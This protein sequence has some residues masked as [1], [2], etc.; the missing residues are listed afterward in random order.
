VRVIVKMGFEV[1]SG[2]I[3][4]MEIYSI[5]G[6]NLD[7]ELSLLERNLG[8][9]CHIYQDNFYNSVKISSNITRHT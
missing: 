3:C 1:V 7:T 6:K 5:E 4:N 9:N 8:Q 2:Y